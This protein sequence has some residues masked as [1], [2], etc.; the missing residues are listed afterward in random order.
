M[1][2]A[3]AERERRRAIGDRALAD[4]VDRHRRAV[5]A[6]LAELSTAGRRQFADASILSAG[7][8][9]F[10]VPFQ[11]Q[12]GREGVV[13]PKFGGDGAAIDVPE[14]VPVAVRS[15]AA[16][17][18]RHVLPRVD[19][20]LPRRLDGKRNAIGRAHRDLTTDV[21]ALRSKLVGA[22]ATVHAPERLGAKPAI[23]PQL[24]PELAWPSHQRAATGE[25]IVDRW[26]IDARAQIEIPE[27]VER[28]GGILAERI[29]LLHPAQVSCATRIESQSP[30][31]QILSRHG[32]ANLDVG[33]VFDVVD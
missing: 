32:L 15:R 1:K 5:C 21:A 26:Q 13:E 19:T 8:E 4:G 17:H 29:G 22:V 10:R 11:R 31:L 12:I 18:A 33:V 6:V 9:R 28:H 3:I 20:A 25:R 7:D 16:S 27:V 14:D 24:L 23:Q 2:V 30:V